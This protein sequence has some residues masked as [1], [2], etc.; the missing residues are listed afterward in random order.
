MRNYHTVTLYVV[1]MFADPI[2][3]AIV[4]VCVCTLVFISI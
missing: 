4:C 1:M 3:V 2:T